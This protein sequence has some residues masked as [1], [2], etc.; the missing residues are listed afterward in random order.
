MH[1]FDCPL[2]YTLITE[3]VDVLL[4]AEELKLRVVTIATSETDGY[5]RFMR[6]AKLFDLNVEVCVQVNFKSH[7][8]V[9]IYMT[10]WWVSLSI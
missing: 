1:S 2:S 7:W 5:K 9:T 10:F 8:E 6:S 3:F 4:H